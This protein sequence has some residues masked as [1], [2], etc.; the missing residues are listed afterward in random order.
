MKKTLSFILVASLLAMGFGYFA[1]NRFFTDY[2]E[3]SYKNY[4]EAADM[5]ER[6]W[7]PEF[8]PKNAEDIRLGYDLDTNQLI[9]RFDKGGADLS[10]I[11]VCQPTEAKASPALS[12][13]W[14]DDSFYAD[15][16]TRFYQCGDNAWL[17]TRGNRAWYWVG[18]KEIGEKDLLRNARWSV[19]R[20]ASETTLPKSAA[21]FLL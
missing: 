12:A 14:W 11:E 8:L 20:F 13:K 1:L 7:I 3:A 5:I 6:G 18:L 15:S 21:L 2:R 17:A 10:H 9:L 19:N 16:Q 4:A